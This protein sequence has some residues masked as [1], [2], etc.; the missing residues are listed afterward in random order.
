MNLTH[1]LAI[2]QEPARCSVSP[3]V[4]ANSPTISLNVCTRFSKGYMMGTE[5]WNPPEMNPMMILTELGRCGG[6]GVRGFPC[7]ADERIVAYG[8]FLDGGGPGKP[9]SCST[10]PSHWSQMFQQS[11]LANQCSRGRSGRLWWRV[12]RG[13]EGE[14]QEAMVDVWR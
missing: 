2:H 3:K 8:C 11:L 6:V 4:Q 12:L 7:L 10:P 14:N 13:R 5:P 9:P 1:Q